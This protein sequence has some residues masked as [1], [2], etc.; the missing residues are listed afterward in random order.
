MNSPFH[1]PVLLSELME[2]LDVS[3]EGIY[4]DCTL[5]LGG[6]AVEI[7]KRNPHA[8]LVGI[9]ID[10]ESLN[11]A[12][13]KLEPY[14]SRVIIYHSDFR[15]LPDI[16]I[17][18]SK[19]KAIY[20]DL[21]MSSF[22]LNSTER[23]FSFNTEGPLDMR[24][25]LRNNLTASKIIN[26]YSEKRLNEIFFKFG[27][28]KQAKRLAHEIVSNR[29]GEKFK[30]TSQL[31]RLCEEVCRWRP[32]KGKIHPAAKVFQA[33]RIEVNQELNNLSDFIEEISE[34]IKKKARIAAISFHSL[35]DRIIKHTFKKLAHPKT[36]NSTLK[37]LTKKPVIP[38]EKEISL[39]PRS[40]SAKLRV[41]EKI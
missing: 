40:R 15:Y 31:R 28:L 38:S 20:M 6:H 5:G 1:T 30:T 41:A 25:D 4:V 11:I 13:K 37:I 26:E 12:R 29:K 17:D 22:Q 9:D 7:L 36:S 34:K 21:G 27:E 32:Q 23:G 19:I 35:E 14:A 33:L 2:Y 24:M 18:F 8:K 3:R 39:N 10:E 16:D